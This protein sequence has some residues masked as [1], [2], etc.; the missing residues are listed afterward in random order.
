[1]TN[2][3]V[4]VTVQGQES[5]SDALALARE[6]YGKNAEP[7]DWW[8]WWLFGR[9]IDCS[10]IALARVGS[11]PVG[12]QPVSFF[13]FRHS[14][15]IVTGAVLTGAMVS[16]GQRGKGIFRALV[17]ASLQEAWRLGAHFVA[18]MP[19]E[20][21]YQAF[22]KFGW[23]D[24]GERTLLR[25]PWRCP[26][27]ISRQYEHLKLRVVDTIDSAEVE[28]VLQGCLAD[29]EFS[30]ERDGSWLKW[31]YRGNPLSS[32]VLLECRDRD[33]ALRSLA[34]GTVR[35]WKRI[36]VGFLVDVLGTPGEATSRV[37]WELSVEIRRR[38][39]LFV[40]TVISGRC[41]RKDLAA[42]GFREAPGLLVSRRFRTV[43]I[44]R[45]DVALGERPP[46]SIDDWR[47]TLADWDGI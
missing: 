24:L 8:R 46:A 35:K 42:A 31:R 43:F 25:A 13:P 47:L 33:G 44:S 16:P 18:T 21:S 30:Q 10:C 20:L 36:P 15:G 34:V 41:L 9:G 40:L 38:G 27:G 12:M 17:N 4:D 5:L 28:R 39:A 22:R 3:V 45:P 37:A 32:Y 19:N 29:R 26:G 6:C 11:Q 1:M 2:L 14:C 23:T 7:E